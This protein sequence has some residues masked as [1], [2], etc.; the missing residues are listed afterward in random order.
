M[1]AGASL[2]APP[3]RPP[4]HRK[5]TPTAC[6]SPS[7]PVIS[8]RVIRRTTKRSSGRRPRLPHSESTW[9]RMHWLSSDRRDASSRSTAERPRQPAAPSCATRC[10]VR[11]RTARPAPS[12]LR[13]PGLPARLVDQLLS[14]QNGL[15]RSG[16]RRAVCSDRLETAQFGAERLKV[17]ARCPWLRRPLWP[18]RAGRRRRWPRLG[19]AAVA[20]SGPSSRAPSLA[21]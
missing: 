15:A 5:G 7:K 3:L 21:G 19:P 16:P 17:W 18:V 10:P 14:A 12:L 11:E 20:P 6:A 8:H 4:P 2:A 9:A 1:L 13:T